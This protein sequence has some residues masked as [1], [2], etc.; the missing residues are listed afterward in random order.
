MACARLALCS[1]EG[2]LSQP[3]SSISRSSLTLSSS[4]NLYFQD[5]VVSSVPYAMYRLARK[6][7]EAKELLRIRRLFKSS[8][9]VVAQIREELAR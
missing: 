2:R 5:S 7:E 4:K 1:S 3:F 6:P 9:L 8:F